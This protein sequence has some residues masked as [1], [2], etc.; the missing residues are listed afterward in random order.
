ME[1]SFNPF[2]DQ[3]DSTGS[4]WI[5]TGASEESSSPAIKS[6]AHRSEKPTSSLPPL[7]AP[8]PPQE[9]K[10]EDFVK[11]LEARLER[12]KKRRPVFAN[13]ANEPAQHVEIGEKELYKTKFE[14]EIEPLLDESEITPSPHDSSF[15]PVS[16]PR[17]ASLAT[18]HISSDSNSDEE[19]EEEVEDP[20][21][22]ALDS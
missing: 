17:Y 1:P 20:S 7:I 9:E 2:G 11:V 21:Y 5:N 6:T 4:D 10:D 18:T 22:G 16:H 12:L 19:S 15:D 3:D 14:A 8:P 13:N